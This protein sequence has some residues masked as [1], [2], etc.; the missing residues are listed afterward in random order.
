MVT[1]QMVKEEQG[2]ERFSGTSSL[3][4]ISAIGVLAVVLFMA[5][6]LPPR[7]A[8]H[9]MYIQSGRYLVQ[10]GK[11]SPLFF[12][13]GHHFPVD[14]A[15]RSKKL[16]YVRVIQPDK[17]A[18]EVALRSETSLHSYFI[19]YDQPG[20]HVLIAETNPG[21]FAMYTDLKGRKRHSLKPLHT[22]ID[23]A[24]S[25]QSSM[26]SSQWAKTYVSCKQ[27]SEIFPAAVGLPLELLPLQ[28]PTSLKEGDSL[29]L[30]IYS[31]AAPY[32]GDGFWD[33][34]YGGYSTEAEDMYIQRTPVAGG[35]FTVSL[36]KSG[37]WFVRFFTKTDAPVDK[38]KEYL[39]EKRTTTLTFEVQNERRRPRVSD[40]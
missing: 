21:Y 31:N 24:M 19:Q 3:M 6:L 29:T 20:T 9:S 35:S 14:E 33:A 36:D 32:T 4:G 38:Q 22:F 39:T 10:E 17:Q 16:S 7:A 34:T 37:R 28:D 23:K 8:A 27:G 40:H 5:V 18:T 15:M 30:Q 13:F 12:C 26:R 25:I 11:G 2:A 1:T